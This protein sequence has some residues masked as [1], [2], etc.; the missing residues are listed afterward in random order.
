MKKIMLINADEELSRMA[1]LESALGVQY[2]EP[3]TREP[4][5]GNIYKGV[6]LKVERAS[7]RSSTT[8]PGS[9]AFVST[10]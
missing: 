4:I 7:R 10:T 3:P 1:V 5:T 9:T 2:P 6:M 8:G